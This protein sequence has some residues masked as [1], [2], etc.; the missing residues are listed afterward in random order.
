MTESELY[1]ILK[2]SGIPFAYHIWKAPPTLPWGVYRTVNQ[3][4]FYADGEIYY[5]IT[6]YDIELYTAKKESKTEKKLEVALSNAG[7]TFTKTELYIESEK[8]YEILYE[9]EV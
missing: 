7:I 9:C 3:S 6:Q 4:K 1:N 2:T 8:L 5:N